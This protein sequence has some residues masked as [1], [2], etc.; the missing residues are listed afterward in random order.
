[1]KQGDLFACLGL[2][3]PRVPFPSALVLFMVGLVALM[4]PGLALAQ[5]QLGIY[6]DAAYTQTEIEV[7]DL[8]SVQ[9]AYL[10][11]RNPDTGSTV[12]GWECCMAVDGPAEFLGWSLEGQALNVV[13]EPCFMVGLGGDGFP[14]EAEILLAT[15]QFQ[16][17][18]TYPVAFSL[19]PA[20][21]PSL[22]DQMAYVSGQGDDSVLLPLV[23]PFGMPEVAFVN[24]NTPVPE[25]TPTEVHFGTHAIGAVRQQ[26]VVVRNVGG[27]ILSLDISLPDLPAD[28]Q[29]TTVSGQHHLAADES[30]QI[31]VTF[32]PSEIGPVT[33]VLDLGPVAGSVPL[34]GYGRPPITSYEIV[35]DLEFGDL[36]VG[37]Q[38]TRSIYIHNT[39]EVDIPV[40]PELGTLCEAF[41]LV[42]PAAFVITPGQITPLSITFQPMSGGPFSCELSLGTVVEALTLTG[43][44]HIPELSWTI[45]PESL[46]F[47]E[48]ALGDPGLQ[49]LLVSN[50]GEA[51]LELDLAV[52][53]GEGAFSLL[54]PTGYQ[55]LPAG[56]TMV[57]QV[58]FIPAVTGPQSA[59]IQLGGPL[60]TVPISGVGVLPDPQCLVDVTEITFPPVS[61]GSIATHYFWVE[62]IGNANIG[63]SPSE[64]SDHFYVTPTP[65]ILAPGDSRRILVQFLPQGVGD[66][67]CDIDLGCDVCPTVHCTGTG[68]YAPP[69]GGENAVGVFFDTYYNQNEY[70]QSEP[71]AVTAYLVLKGV[72]DP[73]GVHG[74]ECRHQID[75]PAVFLGAQ[76]EGL[77][78]NA[79]TPPSFMVGLYEPLAPGPDVL[80]AT[81]QYLLLEPYSQVHLMLEPVDIP[82]IPG[83]MAFT[84]GSNPELALPMEPFTGYEVVAFINVSIVDAQVPAAPTL[85]TNGNSVALSWDVPAGDYEGF[86]VY[87]R[88]D[89]GQETRLTDVPVPLNGEQAS[90][91][92]RPEGFAA[93]AVLHYSYALVREGIEGAHSTEVEYQF[94]PPQVQATRLLPNVPNPFNPQ[95]RIIFELEQAGPCRV[96]IYDVSGRLVRQL[97]S[98]SL[99]AGSHER[100]WQGRDDHGRQVPSGA[101]YVRLESSSGVDSRK[102]MLLK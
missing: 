7:T 55:V 68:E 72:S 82:T 73:L 91:T 98:A 81:F 50:T 62:N 6:F 19:L 32:T 78:V 5:A 41:S 93:G 87:R 45:T 46:N 39:G 25:I 10:V 12:Q 38:V 96:A 29:L 11:M 75:G 20:D 17:T 69:P 35:G 44:A 95:T 43:S 40:E 101:Y 24:A 28:F 9:T 86:H 15:F 56:S 102:I 89:Q 14:P 79:L 16:V 27:G 30:L 37:Q 100:V 67:S 3:I 23:T 51:S 58:N 21:D 18:G 53:G 84:G 22:P 76:L 36:A 83:H 57:I 64:T 8:P 34:E 31:P 49:V 26:N 52:L 47:G 59:D 74:W 1:M 65:M 66:W 71:G 92:D 85:T 42:N 88:E 63:I 60:P 4:S 99:N 13:D 94:Q 48:V 61:V 54:G 77:A 97:E 33:S 70:Y 80:L 90:Y 2:R